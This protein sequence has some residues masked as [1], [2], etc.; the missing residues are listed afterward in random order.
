[1]EMSEIRLIGLNRVESYKNQAFVQYTLNS[2]F[3]STDDGLIFRIAGHVCTYI[4]VGVVWLGLW[5]ISFIRDQL[6]ENNFSN[7]FTPLTILFAIILGDQLRGTLEKV[8]QVNSGYFRLLRLIVKTTVECS[9]C[10][11]KI[12]QKPDRV[13]EDVIKTRDYVIGSLLASLAYY[14]FYKYKIWKSCEAITTFKKMT[15][16]ER[17]AVYLLSPEKLRSL[18]HEEGDVR[19]SHGDTRSKKNRVDG[20]YDVD[21][22]PIK[23]PDR[24][25]KHLPYQ[26]VRHEKGTDLMT[27]TKMGNPCECADITTSFARSSRSVGL[28]VPC[29]S[30]R[31]N[32][33]ATRVHSISN[34][35]EVRLSVCDLALK[36]YASVSTCFDKIHEEIEGILS[37]NENKRP[38]AFERLFILTMIFY[39]HVMI[40]IQFI[41]STNAYWGVVGIPCILAVYLIPLALKDWYGNPFIRAKMTVRSTFI[42]RRNKSCAEIRKMFGL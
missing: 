13:G 19:V 27:Y 37:K 41:S 16:R 34:T 30:G 29:T 33:G 26:I 23:I 22:A 39:T 6:E 4:I 28:R 14:E 18:F 20:L 2:L 10:A 12:E 36:N 7:A 32:S 9:R 11:A 21:R 15:A 40:P 25:L 42:S 38:K 8:T 1:M 24:E 35:G 31:Y 5:Q 3:A 17:N